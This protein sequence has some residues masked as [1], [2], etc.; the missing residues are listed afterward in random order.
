MS[1][2]PGGHAVRQAHHQYKSRIVGLA[3][4]PDG[5]T[6]TAYQACVPLVCV[7]CGAEIAPDAL[8][9]RHALSRGGYYRRGLTKAPVCTACRPLQVEGKDAGE[10]DDAQ[11]R[12]GEHHDG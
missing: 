10:T 7:Q 9:S 12:G 4:Q 3:R 5:T 6:T 1:E 2:T 8:F 11:R